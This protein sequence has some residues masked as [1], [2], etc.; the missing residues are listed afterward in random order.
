M[1]AFFF[2]TLRPEKAALSSSLASTLQ[3]EISNTTSTTIDATIPNTTGIDAAQKIEEQDVSISIIVVVSEQRSSS[4]FLSHDV[5][6][7]LPCHL[8][9]NEILIPSP[10]QSGD[11]WSTVGQ[12]MSLNQSGAK[13]NDPDVLSDF[14]LRV[15]K[16]RCHQK[17]EASQVQQHDNCN[18]HCWVNYKHFGCHLTDHQHEVLWNALLEQ[19]TNHNNRN[20]MPSSMSMIILER[21]VKERWRSKWFAEQTGDWQTRGSAE[22]KAQ[23][24]KAK[25]PVV[26]SK[27]VVEHNRWYR[28]I[29]SYANGKKEMPVV[30]LDFANL[31]QQDVDVTRGILRGKILST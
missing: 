2:F 16:R 6:G 7:S 19:Q 25:V 27:F 24:A 22:H 4:T 1:L 15:A 5:I 20:S 31:T 12:E 30:E 29:R 8:S 26:Q 11:A 3:D 13:D 23:L 10:Q 18:H 14:I 28:R 21:D 17:L 9:L